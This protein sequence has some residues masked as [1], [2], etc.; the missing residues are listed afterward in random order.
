MC[1][2]VYVVSS[3]MLREIPWD[4]SKRLFHLESVT[5]EEGF[6]KWL[7]RRQVY[8]AG[9]HMRCGCGYQKGNAK[10]EQYA[11]IQANYVALSEVV[12]EAVERG[13]NVEVVAC[14]SELASA[15]PEI[16]GEILSADIRRAEFEF[17]EGQHF[18]VVSRRGAA[19]T[20]GS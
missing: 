3:E 19:R 9:T 16:T 4:D 6:W 13:A 18:R 14:F 11:S 1:L 12:R 8:Y 17:K 15:T 10:P 2:A 7:K 5:H 20:S